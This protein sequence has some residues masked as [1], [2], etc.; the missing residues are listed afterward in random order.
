MYPRYI[1]NIKRN[2]RSQTDHAG[3]A[4]WMSG[5]SHGPLPAT[6]R[7]DGDLL[8]VDTKHCTGTMPDLTGISVQ[9]FAQAIMK[10]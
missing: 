10:S 1:T 9:K 4:R 3:E 2:H 7:A 6:G 8:D 5:R